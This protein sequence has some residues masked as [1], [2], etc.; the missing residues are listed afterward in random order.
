MTEAIDAV[1][2]LARHLV[3][4]GVDRAAAWRL[5]LAAAQYDSSLLALARQRCAH[6]LAQAPDDDTAQRALFLLDRTLAPIEST[7]GG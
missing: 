2:G 4:S 1:Y 6:Q 3:S 7:R 5:L